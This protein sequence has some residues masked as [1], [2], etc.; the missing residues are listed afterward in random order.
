MQD[1]SFKRIIEEY[2]KSNVKFLF[3][4]DTNK[5]L[6][7]CRAFSFPL[8]LG[9]DLKN[10]GFKVKENGY[11]IKGKAFMKLLKENKEILTPEEIRTFK[12]IIKTKTQ[13]ME[14]SL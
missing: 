9:K 14:E 12:D 10:V 13:E 1:E 7:K 8:L 11:E 5:E 3:T 6:I 4:T 2:R